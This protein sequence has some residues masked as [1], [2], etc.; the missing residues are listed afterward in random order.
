MST[1]MHKTTE[2]PDDVQQA[3]NL[4][5][6][7]VK[8]L[9]EASVD[10]TRKNQ[11]LEKYNAELAIENEKLLG[12]NEV[13]KAQEKSLVESKEKMN[14]EIEKLRQEMVGISSEKTLALKSVEDAK[15]STKEEEDKKNNFIETIRIKQEEHTAQVEEH[16]RQVSI[17][18]SRKAQVVEL[19]KTI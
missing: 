17:F 5:Q 4:A 8:V 10:F 18:E 1:T 11:V 2:L 19:L 15:V 12:L 6:A 16:N 13:L 3:V 7:K 9:E 14:I